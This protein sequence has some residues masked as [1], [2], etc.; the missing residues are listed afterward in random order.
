MEICNAPSRESGANG[1]AVTKAFVQ[2]PTGAKVGTRSRTPHR[3]T[4]SNAAVPLPHGSLAKGQRRAGY[5][6]QPH[7]CVDRHP[8]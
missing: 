1:V 8:L 6:R 4:T 3:P 5:T 2:D 7:S